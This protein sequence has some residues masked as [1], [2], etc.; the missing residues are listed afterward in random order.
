LV[1]YPKL[2]KR[3]SKKK[4]KDQNSE[5]LK[6]MILR[7]KMKLSNIHKRLLLFKTYN[8]IKGKSKNRNLSPNL[9]FKVIN[10]LGNQ[11]Q[12]SGSAN[13]INNIMK[14]L[15]GAK[16]VSNGVLWSLIDQYSGDRKERQNILNK[17]LKLLK[18]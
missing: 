1:L 9:K 11:L 12:R 6:E 3:R 7:I 14:M 2:S 17:R 8:K 16:S 10:L 18:K 5:F 4:E 13:A 15:I